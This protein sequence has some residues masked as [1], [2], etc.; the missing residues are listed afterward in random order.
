M[1]HKKFQILLIDKNKVYHQIFFKSLSSKNIAVIAVCSTDEAI[2]LIASNK[3]DFIC[4]AYQLDETNGIEFCKLLRK[5]Y[6]NAFKPFVL[7]TSSNEI[8]NLSTALTNGVT[9]V[10]KRADIEELLAFIKRFPNN[11]LS[12]TGK[13]LYIEDDKTQQNIVKK[14]LESYGLSVNCFR[15]A[16]DAWGNFLNNDYD[17]VITDIILAGGVSGLVLCNRIKRTIG[18]KG[19]I[20]ILAV[21]AFD[22]KIRRLEFFHLG[23]NDYL[24]KPL[25]E[26]DLIFR[27]RSMLQQ[28]EITKNA[29]EKE[30]SALIYNNASDAMFV[31]DSQDK[32]IATN[33]AFSQITGYSGAEAFGQSPVFLS[34]NAQDKDSYHYVW[35]HLSNTKAFKGEVFSTHKN[36]ETII[37]N[38]SVKS[39]KS[40]DLDSQYKVAIFTDITEKKRIEAQLLQQANF[41]ELTNL[42][43]RRLFKEYLA[44]ELNKNNRDK[45]SLVVLFLDLDHFK[46]VNDTRGHDIGDLLLA[47]I[48]KRIQHCVRNSD[49]VARIGGDEFAIILPNLV[50]KN[51]A[52]IIAENILLALNKPFILANNHASHQIVISMSIGIAIAPEDSNNLADLIKFA[53]Q[54]MYK[55]KNNGRNQFCYFTKSMQET[56]LYKQALLKDLQHAIKHQEFELYYQ[57]IINLKTKAVDH[58]EALIRWHH[59][60][61]GFITPDKFIPLAEE[62]GL[63]LAIGNWVFEQAATTAKYWTENFNDNFKISINKSPV[64]FHSKSQTTQWLDYL[65]QINLSGKQLIIELTEGILLENNNSNMNKLDKYRQC[66]I[67][68]SIDDFGTGYSSLSYLQKFHVDLL[69]IDKCFIN[70]LYTKKSDLIL[71]EAIIA[72]AHKLGII[73]IAEGVE[74]QKQY[75]RLEQ[76]NCDY[77][78]GYFIAKPLK[79]KDFEQLFFK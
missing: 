67:A 17:L 28:Q 23:I 79:Q 44:L 37:Q 73:V 75:A 62:S 5:K 4:C 11:H 1:E 8:K 13:V 15:F 52:E 22:D 54:A 40:S 76:L 34:A 18:Q 74:T 49:T 33:P 47:A 25:I 70:S 36:G 68:L 65:K 16:E 14:M 46:D 50:H 77:V 30:I 2:P 9:D 42:P 6:I 35:Q 59:P 64:Q 27:I 20:P 19:D 32:I 45:T 24:I 60:T 78:Q 7:L 21:T 63:I 10:F 58:A 51:K 48:A 38:L 53:D 69:K 61:L 43:N 72:M 12:L 66:G 29:Q 41:D 71:S 57:P 3:V 39:L 26:E 31:V 56:A 55:A